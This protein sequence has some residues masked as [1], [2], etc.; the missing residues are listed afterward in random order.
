M[1]NNKLRYIIFI[2]AIAI[3]AVTIFITNSFVSELSEEER[4]KMEIWAE[5]T[6]L[7]L[8]DEYNDFIFMIVEY[9]E[10]IPVIIA[11]ENDNYISARNFKEPSQNVDAFY[12][13]QIKRLK[14][15][16]IPIEIILDENEKQYI[17]YDDSLMLKR[18]VYFPYIQFTVIFLFLF[19]ILWAFQSTK[20]SE[21]NKL[22]VGLSKETAHQLGTPITS[23]F[24]WIELLKMKYPDEKLLPDINKDIERLRTIADRFSKIGS[25]PDLN[26]V[27]I[28]EII[29]GSMKYM[30][31]RTSKNIRYNIIYNNPEI[32]SLLCPPLFEW[33]IENLCKNAL[34]AMDCEGSIT[35]NIYN[36]DDGKIIIDVT[37][38]G[39]GMERKKYKTVFK[40]GYTTK[41]RGWGLGLALTKR[42]IEEYH[43][44]KIFVKHSQIGV[45]TTFRIIMPEYK[46]L[47]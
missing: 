12:S 36:I 16:N 41:K 29:S 27:N 10:N 1:A 26:P 45:G 2:F 6:K 11:D 33:V 7:M 24:A 17:Y 23:L 4:R 46:G 28:V 35:A 37:D 42:I 15:K 19:A 25:K 47:Q 40:P 34:D 9:N 38:T 14:E 21:Q 5:A 20:H 44:G 18:L 3:T 13:K 30:E 32:Y 39:K 43:N 31:R 22:W 8:T